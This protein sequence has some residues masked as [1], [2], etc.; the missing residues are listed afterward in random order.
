MFI[1]IIFFGGKLG[2]LPYYAFTAY[3]ITELGGPAYYVIIAYLELWMR[4][5]MVGNII[6]RV[7]ASLI[8]NSFV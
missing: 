3:Y 6:L 5:H 4:I 7:I 1:R 8:F 2:L